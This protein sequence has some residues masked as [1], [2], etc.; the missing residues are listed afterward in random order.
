MSMRT[1]L[2]RLVA[3]AWILLF[4]LP[5]IPADSTVTGTLVEIGCANVPFGKGTAACM[6]RCAKRGEPIGIRTDEG[7]YTITGD[8][9]FQNE[10]QLARLMT[11]EVRAI[12]EVTGM[13]IVIT[14]MEP[15]E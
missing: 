2:L 4:S 1:N 14:S 10:E 6:V 12:G 8:W 7:T 5:V 11:K 13:T 3:S 15:A 9:A